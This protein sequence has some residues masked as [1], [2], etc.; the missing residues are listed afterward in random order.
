MSE[1]SGP[2][3]DQ[4]F[5]A[6]Q[7]FAPERRAEPLPV[8]PSLFPEHTQTE[9]ARQTLVD[10]VLS[11]YH[12]HFAEGVEGDAINP[13]AS[14]RNFDTLLLLT[15]LIRDKS[16]LNPRRR[17]EDSD[18]PEDPIVTWFFDTY[19]TTGIE[20]GSLDKPN[21]I[22]ELWLKKLGPHNDMADAHED[23]LAARDWLLAV[24][25]EKS[26]ANNGFDPQTSKEFGLIAELDIELAEI[27]DDHDKLPYLQEAA[28]YLNAYIAQKEA[29][30]ESAKA[31]VARMKLAAVHIDIKREEL[32]GTTMPTRR[33]DEATYGQFEQSV[34]DELDSLQAYYEEHAE[35][36]EAA[37]AALPEPHT[38]KTIGNL[39][40]E[41]GPLFE[42]FTYLEVMHSFVQNGSLLTQK[43]RPGTMREESSTAHKTDDLP[44]QE[45]RNDHGF[46]YNFDLVVTTLNDGSDPYQRGLYTSYYYQNKIDPEYASVDAA[47]IASAK[48]FANKKFFY[49]QPKNLDNDSTADISSV[50]GLLKMLKAMTKKESQS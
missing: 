27:A 39:K 25:S 35:E 46:N 13:E 44:K 16:T 19:G 5:V 11:P 7:T 12:I 47:T 32:V 30:G 34:E 36:V 21:K 40:R 2:S 29:S 10:E 14:E 8:Q 50:D 38:E 22:V 26:G 15:K 48:F 4:N 3:P 9:N 24:N 17:Q 33:Y 23:L 37:F 18:L 31:T 28:T 45:S 41:L 42:V 20:R 1:T 49:I 6:Q 43:I